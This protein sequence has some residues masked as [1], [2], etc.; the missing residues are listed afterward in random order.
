MP[1]SGVPVLIIGTNQPHVIG[2][3][4]IAIYAACC[5]P[6]AA[7]SCNLS[8]IAISITGGITSAWLSAA[9]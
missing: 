1:C 3:Y 6:A 7:N 4:T 5:I 9:A 2:I 8:A